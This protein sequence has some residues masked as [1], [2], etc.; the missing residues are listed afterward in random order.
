M[1][2][3]AEAAPPSKASA[4]RR[5]EP[6]TISASALPLAQPGRETISCITAARFGVRWSAPAGA[7][8]SA[9]TAGAQPPWPS[10]A[11]GPRRSPRPW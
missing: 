5:P 3:R 9:T 10:S 4:V 2:D 8:P 7:R 1:Q 11:A 6:V